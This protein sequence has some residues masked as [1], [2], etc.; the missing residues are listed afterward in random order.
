M[1]RCFSR[2]QRQLWKNKPLEGDYQLGGVLT[3]IRT[4]SHLPGFTQL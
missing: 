1:K 4:L 3:M 2:K